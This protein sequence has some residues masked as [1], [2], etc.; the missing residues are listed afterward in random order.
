VVGLG[1]DWLEVRD[2]SAEPVRAEFDRWTACVA[3]DRAFVDAAAGRPGDTAAGRPVDPPGPPDYG[4][5]LR[6][7]RLAMAVARS[8]ASGLPERLA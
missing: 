5:A 3:A 4:E 2:G 1:E 8:A 7:H 6:S